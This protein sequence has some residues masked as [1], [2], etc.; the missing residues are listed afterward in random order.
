MA[1]FLLEIGTDEIPAR[2]LTSATEELAR[3]L[4]E[5]I[6]R[7]HLATSATVES[8]STPRRIAVLAR[9]LASSQADTEEQVMGPATK[10]AFKDGQPTPA[11]EAFARKVGLPLTQ[12][13]KVETP[14]GEYLSAK[15]KK[16]GRTASE[17]LS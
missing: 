9:G 17:L 10:V 14:K 3:R 1:D 12:I 2:M 15:V 7:E 4:R 8:F 11:A 16:Q 13:E 6:A 5:L